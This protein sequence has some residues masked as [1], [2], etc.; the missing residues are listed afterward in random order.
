MQV[1]LSLRENVEEIAKEIVKSITW[2]EHCLINSCGST[3]FCCQPVKERGSYVCFL[4]E[5]HCTES[6][7]FLLSYQNISA[8]LHL[9]TDSGTEHASRN[10]DQTVADSSC[11]LVAPAIHSRASST[12]SSCRMSFRRL[13]RRTRRPLSPLLRGTP[14]MSWRSDR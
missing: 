8:F 11:S 5:I 10:T 6:V 12:R 9:H 1:L 4:I 2:R 14:S 13:E 7:V 3:S